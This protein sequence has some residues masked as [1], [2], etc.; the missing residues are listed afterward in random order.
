[1]PRKTT[2]ARIKQ[3]LKGPLRALST[4]NIRSIEDIDAMIETVRKQRLGTTHGEVVPHQS[5]LAAPIFDHLG[6]IVASLTIIGASEQVDVGTPTSPAGALLRAADLVSQRLGFWD[7]RV[8][9]SYVER[10]ESEPDRVP[11][12]LRG[13]SGALTDLFADAQRSAR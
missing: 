2:A 12:R 13:D 8:G 4:S 3:E 9:A 10:L 1:M 5:A 7:G 11:E 6:H